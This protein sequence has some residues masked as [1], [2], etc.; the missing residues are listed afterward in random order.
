MKTGNGC[1]LRNGNIVIQTA[2][3]I[4]R[5]L[6]G[7]GDTRPDSR[8]AARESS[9]DPARLVGWHNRRMSRRAGLRT[10]V[11]VAIAAILVAGGCASPVGRAGSGMSIGPGV[12]PPSAVPSVPPSSASPAPSTG[13]SGATASPGGSPNPS[14]AA[15]YA[16]IESEVES[17]RE[18]RARSPVN[19]VLLD[20][21]GVAA[22]L[23]KANA[24]QTNHVALAEKSRL[25]VDLG[26]LPPGS[27]LEQLELDLQSSQVIGF[28]D[29]VSKGLYVLSESGGVGALEKIT[30]SHEFTHAL[31]DQNF[32]LDKLALD[33]PEQSDRDLARTAL[34]EGDATLAMTLWSS[35]YMS[36]PE[37]LSVAGDSGAAAQQQ[38]LD[39]APPIL[40]D[41]LEFPYF[42]GLTF[43]RGIYARGGWAAVDRVYANPPASTSQILH[44]DLYAQ[45][46]TPVQVGVPAVPSSLPGWQLTTQDTLGEYELGVWLAGA[47]ERNAGTADAVSQWGGDRV[48][49]YEGPNGQWAVVLVTAW[50]SADGATAFD[51]AVRTLLGQM[52]GVSRVCNGSNT[53]SVGQTWEG[54][55]LASSASVLGSFAPCAG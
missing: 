49:L 11:T 17:I 25:F 7:S 8:R 2:D 23:D 4:V 45:G 41:T 1:T 3:F 51:G 43:V 30:F 26:L 44:P 9:V 21:A 24:E 47:G 55:Y 15:I 5:T 38:Q 50:R 31:Q 20:S 40:R 27:S 13:S 12:P 42:Q 32:G 46:V 36:L 34:P 14:D 18:L 52:G 54:V 28:Y 39:A 53:K 35:R 10:W 33:T 48:A 37:L 16:R 29:P 22:W 6:V 19:P